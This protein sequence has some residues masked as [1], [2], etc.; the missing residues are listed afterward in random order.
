MRKRKIDTFFWLFSVHKHIAR[1]F[2]YFAR[3]NFKIKLLDYVVYI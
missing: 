1:H 2:D 3:N